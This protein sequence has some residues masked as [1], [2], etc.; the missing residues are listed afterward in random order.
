MLNTY[1]ENAL[2]KSDHSTFCID[3][4]AVFRSLPLQNP[5]RKSNNV[6]IHPSPHTFLVH[7]FRALRCPKTI[8]M[9]EYLIPLLGL[10][11]IKLFFRILSQWINSMYLKDSAIKRINKRSFVYRF[12]VPA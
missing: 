11:Q 1:T 6:Y 3:F 7:F 12:T 10:F 2:H 8:Q 9:V 4:G 5:C